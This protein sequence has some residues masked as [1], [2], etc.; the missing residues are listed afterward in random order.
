MLGVLLA[1]RAAARHFGAAGGG[2]VNTRFAA[3]TLTPRA[4]SA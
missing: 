1:S 2:I 3:T 4:A